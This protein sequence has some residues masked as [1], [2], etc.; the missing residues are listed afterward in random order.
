MYR[1]V[2]ILI[3]IIVL[4]IIKFIFKINFK[5]I[6]DI[7]K[8]NKSSELDNITK[9]LPD[10]ETVCKEIL[11]LLNNTNVKIEKDEQ[12]QSCLYTV[13]NNK[14]TL[15]KFTSDY[16]RVQTIAHE[17]LH[18]VQ[19]KRILLSNFII[20]NIYIFYFIIFIILRILKINIYAN[21][22]FPVF[23]ILSMLQFALRAYL[24]NDAM[25]KAKYVA[26]EYLENTKQCSNEEIEK[27]MSKYDQI[28]Q[29]GIPTTNFILLA[30]N[31]IKIMIFSIL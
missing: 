17:C 6:K 13:F 4:A 25:T 29:M 12:Y 31:I 28:N 22:T 30:K 9:K 15:G 3:S 14:I 8:N 2:I 10:D 26:K 24:E 21:I 7:D 1:L 18:S 5:E 20:S 27:L 16:I 19:S 23:I 11:K